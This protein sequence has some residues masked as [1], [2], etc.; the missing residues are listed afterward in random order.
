M[1]KNSRRLISRNDEVKGLG[2]RDTLLSTSSEM[3]RQESVPYGSMVG[4]DDLLR[5]KW[6]NNG[7]NFFW[8][9][10]ELMD[11]NHA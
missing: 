10:D 7:Q 3:T 11:F 6:Q 2:E 5:M 4:I 1:E 9:D 8:G